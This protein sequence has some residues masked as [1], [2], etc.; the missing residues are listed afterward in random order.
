LS[1]F[2]RVRAQLLGC[3]ALVAALTALV[4]APSAGAA[5]TKTYLALGDSLAFSYQQATFN[6]GLP[7]PPQASFDHGYVDDFYLGLKLTGQA[8]KLVN[9]GCPGET[10]TSYLNGP[11]GYQAIGFG[12]HHPYAGGPFS[13]QK[14]DALGYIAAHPGEVKVISVD[15][16]ANDAL[17]TING[18]CNRDPACIAAH[19]PALFASIAGNLGT[20][21]GQ[22]RA[23]APTAKVVVL[24]LYNPFGT[25]LAGADTLTASLNTV[26]KGVVTSLGA[27]F[28]NP[29]P[30]FNP[31]GALEATT[32]C[33]FTNMCTPLVDIHPTD[34]GYAVLGGV[35]GAAYL[36]L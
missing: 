35:V 29:F 3:L 33:A 18:V 6:A 13:S 32:I 4:L 8:N 22:L 12:L 7:N 1:R 16:G 26:L 24:G 30:L 25:A 36:G 34:L 14:S 17:A 23:A 20:V 27:K 15:L 21:V 11:C 19:A 31:G 28:A 2:T 9:D 5:T 10:T